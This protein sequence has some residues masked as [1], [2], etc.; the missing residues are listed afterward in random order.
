MAWSNDPHILRGEGLPSLDV[1]SDEERT[2]ACVLNRGLRALADAAQKGETDAQKLL[3]TARDLID[4][5]HLVVLEYLEMR[6]LDAL[7]TLETLQPSNTL[8]ALAAKVGKARLI[9]NVRL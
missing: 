4:A 6:S 9:D 3:S 2:A 5:E 7:E 8:V 1:L